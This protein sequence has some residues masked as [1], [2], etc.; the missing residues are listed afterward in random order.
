M[1]HRPWREASTTQIALC[2]LSILTTGS[3]AFN[4]L[5]RS[6]LSFPRSALGNFAGNLFSYNLAYRRLQTTRF[7]RSRKSVGLRVE[8]TA[9][10]PQVRPEY[11]QKTLLWNEAVRK[12]W[13]EYYQ[14]VETESELY[15]TDIEGE[16]PPDF[17]ATIFRN[18]PGKFERGE[19]RVVNVLD[20]DGHIVKFVVDGASKQAHMTNR[21]V[22]TEEFVAE[23]EQDRVL[24][25]STFGTQPPSLTG[26]FFNLRLKNPANTN[27]QFCGDKLLALWEAGVPYVINPW[28]LATEGWDDLEKSL[29]GSPGSLTVTTGMSA[30]DS[31]MKFGK[32]FTAHP[33]YD[34][35]TK[36]MVGWTWAQNP[37][38]DSLELD[39]I[40]WGEEGGQVQKS[41]HVIEDCTIAPHDFAVTSSYYVFVLNQFGLTLAPYLMGLKGPAECLLATGKGTTVC[42]IPRPGSK[43][44]GTEPVL[45]QTD[46]PWF[47]IHHANAYEELLAEVPGGVPDKVVAYSTGWDKM[48]EGP[49]LSDWG[50]S[51][52]DFDVVPPSF[53]FKLDIDLQRKTVTRTKCF[54]G[55]SDHAHVDPHFEGRKHRYV[56]TVSGNTGD[57][58]SPCTAWVRYDCLTGETRRWQSNAREFVEEP[59][60]IPKKGNGNLEP[61]PEDNAQ[62]WLVG[63]LYSAER[64]DSCLAILDG[65]N[66][67]AGPV[68]RLWCG[69]P[70]PNGLHGCYS[71]RLYSPNPH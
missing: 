65:A 14:S 38:T 36:R 22:R 66:L 25:R 5:P 37:L 68:C 54:N 48:T 3:E 52:P 34:A 62:V 11:G 53:L 17:S 59:L 16:I 50:G 19:Q 4:L 15:I 32:A 23:E 6:S 40:E 35:A 21:F 18:G 39:V 49:F 61:D 71:P 51:V 10:D 33:H 31:L 63:L 55:H 57:F 60:L 43:A 7:S 69:R 20:G 56:Y 70:V 9:T 1:A 28:T 27:I 58:S 44:A 24:F 2:V 12:D 46:D 42:L 41:S 8:A 13:E 45:I 29:S 30:V 47:V 26:N 67:E 64:R